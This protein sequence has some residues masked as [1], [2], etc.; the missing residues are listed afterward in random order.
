M[1]TISWVDEVVIVT[2][3][4]AK[5]NALKRPGY[6]L[7]SEGEISAFPGIQIKRGKDNQV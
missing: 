7:D 4:Q 1:T 2:H 3:G 6:D 5:I